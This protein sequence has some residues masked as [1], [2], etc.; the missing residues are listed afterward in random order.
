M[1]TRAS[2]P[3]LLGFDRAHLE[4]LLKA[5]DGTRLTLCSRTRLD[6][7]VVRLV[8]DAACDAAGRELSVEVKIAPTMEAGA[9][10]YLGDA[11][12]VVLDPRATWLSGIERRLRERI[13]TGGIGD[14]P[15]AY[16]YLLHALAET[17]ALPVVE[18]LQDTGT[19]TRIG[20]SVATVTGLRAVG[21]QEIVQFEGG[22]A[23]IAFSLR[24]NDVGVVLLGGEELVREGSDVQ[25]SGHALRVPAGEAMLGRVI[26]PVGRP[27]D[28]VGS[29]VPSA[30]MP[31]ERP[32]PG[33]VVRQPVDT[34][35][36][37][38]LK[39]IDALVPIGRGQRELIIG[40]RKIG[41]T[42]IAIDAILAQKN[43]GVRCVYC[44]IG[45]KASSVRQLV[46]TLEKHGALDYTAV[47]AAL[48][49]DVPAYRYLA[50]FTACALGEYFLDRGMDALVVYDDLSKHAVTYREISALLERPVGREAYPGD[51]FYLHSRLLER[52]CR[53]ADEFGG[54]SLTAL[55]IVETLAGDI[56][57][58][59]P[60]NNIS[61]SDGQIVL[62]S[63]AFN[64]GRRPAMDAGLSVSRVGGAAQAKILKRVAGRLRIDL[65][66]YQEMARFVKFGAEVDESTQRQL[67]RGER[68]RV[69]LGQALHEP[70]PL[71]HEVL[72]LYAAVSGLFDGTEV[73]DLAGAEARLLQ[74][75][76]KYRSELVRE[77]EQADDLTAE[78]EERMTEAVTSF[79]TEEEQAESARAG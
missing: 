14:A 17:P 24:D 60:T 36:H 39:V 15:A 3:H 10:L 9:I 51:I 55:P 63:V 71:A 34:P 70:M 67:T 56:S 49:G 5:W 12:R 78:L 47:V 66:Q 40:D 1:D 73:E 42:V 25:R 27:I 7:A 2:S 79:F 54:G 68:A 8:H 52:A 26:D 69:L 64:E 30:W 35:L 29:V 13:E 46:A 37:T 57:A 33:V 45:Q 38:G 28:G 41:K 16:E 18:A 43:T 21:S 74:W 31:I 61:I 22:G 44:A 23:G 75:A 76:A 58:F 77:L 19:V 59:I 32:A 11:G 50:P 20:D 6:D 48:P 65:A 4:R 53:L 72:V 62:D